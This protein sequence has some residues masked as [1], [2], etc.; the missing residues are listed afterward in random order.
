MHAVDVQYILDNIRTIPNWPEKGVMF[1]DITPLFQDPKAL[2]GFMDAFIQRYIDKKLDVVAGIDARGFLIGVTIA[3]GLNLSFVP[4]RKKGKL[5]WKTI[6]K[7]YD[8]EYGK[9]EIEIHIDAIRPGDR[10]IIIDDL[11][12]TGGTMIA[13]IDLIQQLGG[14]VV[15][16]AAIIDLVDLGGSKKIKERYN[17]PVFTI[18]SFDGK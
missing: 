7:Q 17:I 6:S 10:V 4:I 3:Y 9:E 11:I 13:G 15:E 5:P 12:A 2:R 18:C 8:L 16:A 1:R 14:E